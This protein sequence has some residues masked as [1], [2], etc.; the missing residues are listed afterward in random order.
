MTGLEIFTHYEMGQPQMAKY[1]T[2]FVPTWR[3]K[4][5]KKIGLGSRLA[6]CGVG[7][8]L[9]GTIDDLEP[10]VWDGCPTA[11]TEFIPL[12]R[13]PGNDKFLFY[14]FLT[15]GFFKLKCNIPKSIELYFIWANC[16]VGKLYLKLYFKTK[17][18]LNNPNSGQ[19]WFV[20]FPYHLLQGRKE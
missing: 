9:F 13:M 17:S 6:L 10:N 4:N 15:W 3:P 8:R 19:L 12:S 5:G 2:H 7:N 1:C 14:I 11:L 20:L 18:L 16:K